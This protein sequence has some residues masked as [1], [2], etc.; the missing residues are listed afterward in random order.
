MCRGKDAIILAGGGLES[1]ECKFLLLSVE[2]VVSSVTIMSAVL[3]QRFGNAH[4][5]VH[6]RCPRRISSN[7]DKNRAS[8]YSADHGNRVASSRC[9]ATT[10]SLGCWPNRASAF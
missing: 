3:N 5:L 1:E 6:V 2:L 9:P 4:R 10:I 7:L 8:D